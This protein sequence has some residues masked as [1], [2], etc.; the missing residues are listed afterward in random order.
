MVLAGESYNDFY[1][2][3]PFKPRLFL[4]FIKKENLQEYFAIHKSFSPF[5]KEDFT[6]AHKKSYIDSF[7]NETHPLCCSN[8]LPWSQKLAES[9]CYTNGGLYSAVK[10]SIENPHIITLS[11]SGG[12][13]RANPDSGYNFST[14]SGQV[15]ASVK[16]F[17]QTGKRGAWID[18]GGDKGVSISQTRKFAPEL[19]EAIP[20]GFEI[21]PDGS[22]EHYIND[23][24]EKL[25]KLEEAIK[26]GLIHYIVLCHGADSHVYDAFGYQ[27]TTEEWIRASKAVYEL[28]R[29]I[30]LTY[31]RNIPFSM[32]LF[33][34][35]RSESYESVLSLHLADMASCLNILCGHNIKYNPVVEKEKE[36]I[37]SSES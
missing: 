14:F 7:F 20:E 34:G 1:D 18:L 21:F 15:I 12:F 26:T 5:E 17:N 11:P 8:G 35:Y 23:L 31:G 37:A 32:V 16:I 9:V 27:C 22:H 28:I 33:G 2:K 10:Y 30:D 25:V 13:H 19:N 36:A 3:T 24:E 4:N 29:R 6:I